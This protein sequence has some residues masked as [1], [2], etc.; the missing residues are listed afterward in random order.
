MGMKKQFLS[1]ILALFL[2]LLLPSVYSQDNLILNPSLE[3]GIGSPSY[4]YAG[5]NAYWSSEGHNGI[6]SIGLNPSSASGDWRSE[7]FNVSANAEYH[8]EFWVKGTYNSGEFYVYVRWFSDPDASI[9]IS[10]VPFRIMGNYSNWVCVNDTVTS[11][12]NAITCD[13]FFRAEG[14]SS[15][16]ILTDDY[17]MYQIVEES[18]IVAQWFNELFFG[19]GRWLTLIVML[20][21]IVVVVGWNAYAG[22]LFM[23]ITIFLSIFY[24]R[25]IPASS[26]FMW[27]AVTMLASAIYILAM[28]I[29]KALKEK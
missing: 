18:P 29:R 6:H 27:G 1:L 16:N 15:G 5:S 25:N 26:D 8:F 2:C 3:K 20:A 12:S 13:I 4:W 21:I 11:P 22:T 9:F 14:T 19:S 7:H 28:L 23:P 24:F 17:V 10:Q